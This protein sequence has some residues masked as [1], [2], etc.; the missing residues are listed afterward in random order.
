MRAGRAIS[1]SRYKYPDAHFS[2]MKK[3]GV[4]VEKHLLA[5]PWATQPNRLKL[6]RPT[7]AEFC[8]ARLGAILRI[9]Q[10]IVNPENEA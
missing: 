9:A 5:E 1:A 4:P 10:R 2:R 7:Y 8:E 6:D 3:A